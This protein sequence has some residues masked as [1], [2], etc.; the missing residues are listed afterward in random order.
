V[1]FLFTDIEGSTRLWDDH[2]TQMAEAVA[3][4]DAIVR[5]SMVAHHGFVFATGGDGFAVAFARA[6]DAVSAAVETQ[7]RLLAESWPGGVSLGVRVG[8]CIGEAQERGGD[9]FGSAVNRAA[10]VMAAGHGRPTYADR[11]ETSMTHNLDERVRAV[12]HE[13][14]RTPAV[15]YDGRVRWGTWAQVEPHGRRYRELP[16]VNRFPGPCVSCGLT[17]RPGRGVVVEAVD[18]PGPLQLRHDTCRDDMGTDLGRYLGRHAGRDLSVDGNLDGPVLDMGAY[19][20]LSDLDDAL[21]SETVWPDV[22]L[23]RAYELP[24]LVQLHIAEA[25]RFLAAAGVFDRA[26]RPIGVRARL[27][28]VTS[29]VL[30]GPGR[31]ELGLRARRSKPEPVLTTEEQWDESSRRVAELQDTV[32]L[33]D[34]LTGRRDVWT[35]RYRDTTTPRAPTGTSCANVCGRGA[36]DD[37]C[38]RGPRPR[39]LRRLPA[40]DGDHR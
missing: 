30:P 32:G 13:H 5:G 18:R 22:T 37:R 4:H 10:R 20:T 35:E 14:R 3:R 7:R 29:L 6:S 31:A 28:T 23:P 19:G 34:R 2:P 17:V 38:R 16:V 11:A 26:D 27:A 24:D 25:Q 36:A 33:H 39:H 12:M 8:L 21:V 40:R 15:T 9:Y 1:T